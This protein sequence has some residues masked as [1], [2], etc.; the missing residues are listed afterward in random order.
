MTARRTAPMV[1]CPRGG[2]SSQRIHSYYTRRPRDLP[3][4]EDTGRL[5][6]Y[7][8]CVRCVNAPYPTQTFTE[9]LPPIGPPTAQRTVRL[10]T[11]LLQLGLALGG[12][13]VARLRAT[14]QRSPSPEPLRRLVHQLP[15][16]P[17]ATP[18]ILG[19]ANRPHAVQSCALTPS[20][21]H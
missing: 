20:L 21:D 19:G 16:L 18:P 12:G 10:T 4:W 14:R 6:L 9:R 3:L 5:V 7:V 11:A 17:M 8:R 2:E 15:E 1:S 13:A